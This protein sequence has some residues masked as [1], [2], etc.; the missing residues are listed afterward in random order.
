MSQSLLAILA[1]RRRVMQH[2]SRE[3]QRRDA[4]R[5]VDKKY[6]TPGRLVRDP[7]AQRWAKRRRDDHG[8]S[9]KR[10]GLTAFG[11]R[12]GVGEDGLLA[13]RKPATA[14]SLEHTKDDQPAQRRRQSTQERAGAK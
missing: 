5:H 13:R 7:T 11:R 1:H 4:Y 10:E 3:Q 12:K 9:V 2:P 14:N 8:N 6:P